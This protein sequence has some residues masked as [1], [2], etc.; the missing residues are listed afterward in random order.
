MAKI[1]HHPR[2]ADYIE[3]LPQE[4]QAQVDESLRYLAAHGRAAQLPDVRH[5]IAGDPNLTETRNQA[6]IN[7]RRY[8]I[9]CL[10]VFH[11]DDHLLAAVIGDKDQWPDTKGD[12]YDTWVPVARR[13]YELMKGQL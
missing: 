13:V 10:L 3:Q 8:T 7:G 2:V 6:T 9:R 11:T 12:W 5:R 1:V 4:L